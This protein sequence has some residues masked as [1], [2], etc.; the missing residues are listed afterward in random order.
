LVVI[1]IVVVDLDGDGDLDVARSRM[2]V[3]GRR[4]PH[5]ASRVADQVHVAVAVKV[6]DHGRED[7]RRGRALPGVLT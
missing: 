6:H 4:L 3:R 2:A 5:Y 1:L 7:G